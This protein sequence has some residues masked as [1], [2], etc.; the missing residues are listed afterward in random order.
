MQVFIPLSAVSATVSSFPPPPPPPPPEH[1]LV[2]VAG[3]KRHGRTGDVETDGCW[4]Q[5]KTQSLTLMGL[6]RDR[7]GR[8]HLGLIPFNQPAAKT[9]I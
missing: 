7:E 5:L 2:A 6:K 4:H 9:Q 8:P 3:L 1:T